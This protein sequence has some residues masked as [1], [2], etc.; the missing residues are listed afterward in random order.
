M[1][2]P[3]SSGVW[4]RGESMVLSTQTTAEGLVEWAAAEMVGMSTILIKGFVGVSRST[5]AVL[6]LKTLLTASGF[7]VST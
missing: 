3:S 1:S 2:A 5:M 6:E 7:V 4:R